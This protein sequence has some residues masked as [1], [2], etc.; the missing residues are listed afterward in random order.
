MRIQGA[1]KFDGQACKAPSPCTQ[2]P[3]GQSSV[4]KSF[5]SFK[6]HRA[7]I[8]LR[9]EKILRLHMIDSG[10]HHINLLN[11]SFGD[12]S[13]RFTSKI[14]RFKLLKPSFGGSSFQFT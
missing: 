10:V 13:L 7:A 4:W 14:H 5:E 12:S 11:P 2:H 9:V 8:V 1:I 3:R 6:Y